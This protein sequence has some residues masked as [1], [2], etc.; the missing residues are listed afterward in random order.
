MKTLN[1]S[2]LFKMN[3]DYHDIITSIGRIS[4]LNDKVPKNS[5]EAEFSVINRRF[6]YGTEKF[7]MS[8]YDKDNIVIIN[9]DNLKLPKY[10]SVVGKPKGHNKEVA[11]IVNIADYTNSNGEIFP[12]TLFA[13]L[14]NAFI[15]LE[16]YRGWNKYINNIKFITIN[17]YLYSRV[18]TKIFDKLFS[19]DLN[20]S[21][22]DF[23]SFLFAKFFLINLCGKEDNELIDNIAYKSCFN[24]TSLTVIKND[25]EELL[26]NLEDKSKTMYSDIFAL[27]EALKKIPTLEKCNIR[28]FIENYI[29]MYGESTLLTLDYL[30]AFLSMLYSQVVSGN[31]NKEYML[32][33]VGKNNIDKSY[34]QFLSML[35]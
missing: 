34:V 5:L 8:E 19:I 33:Q 15:N 14:Q 1:D 20:K 18:T 16:L 31:L 12:R 26:M 29:R 30:P 35:K 32:E 4:L 23:V 25:E 27:F 11:M 3:P 6:N 21:A 17:S 2:A 7:V 24:G 28:T 13:L 22:S 9:K 10:L